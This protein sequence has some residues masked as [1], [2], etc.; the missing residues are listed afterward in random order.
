MRKVILFVVPLALVGLATPVFAMSDKDF[1]D[2]AIQGDN[3]EAAI[4]YLAGDRAG[5][6]EARSV[7]RTIAGDHDK[8]R[9]QAVRLAD[10]RG[11]ISP[12]TPSAEGAAE[13]AKLKTLSGAAFDKEFAAFLV[14]AHEKTIAAFEAEA[15][16]GE[17][18][19]AKFAD[20][21]V[22]MLQKHLDMA[23]KLAKAPGVAVA[24]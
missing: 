18:P 2:Y 17:G 22:P 11:L 19:V 8:A 20:M 13:L 16:S 6:A 21:S 24:K 10:L 23:E 1:L 9:I 15:H 4:G 12:K 7:G 5:S 3:T 14:R